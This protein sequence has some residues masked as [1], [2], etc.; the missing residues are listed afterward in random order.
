L[1]YYPATGPIIATNIAIKS[2]VEDGTNGTQDQAMLIN[3]IVLSNPRPELI[4]SWLQ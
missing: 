3:K 4:D 2:T 1:E